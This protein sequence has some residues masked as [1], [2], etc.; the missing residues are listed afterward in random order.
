MDMQVTLLPG[1]MEPLW[2]MKELTKYLRCSDDVARRL[3]HERNLPYIQYG[4]KTSPLR[5]R[6]EEVRQWVIKNELRNA[7]N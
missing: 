3:V 7:V 2:G 4:E 5:F 6:P 1:G